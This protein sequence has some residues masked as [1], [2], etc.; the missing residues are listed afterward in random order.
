MVDMDE[1]DEAYLK[2]AAARLAL[3]V[4]A[5]DWPALQIA[6]AALAAQAAVVS[7][8]NISGETEAAPRFVP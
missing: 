2:A 6:F 1:P 4:R 7:N 8:T 5:E 3:P